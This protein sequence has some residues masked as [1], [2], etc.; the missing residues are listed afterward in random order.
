MMVEVVLDPPQGGEPVLVC[1]QVSEG[2]SVAAAVQASG[3]LEQYGGLS[4]ATASIG[5]HGKEVPLATAL[6]D[7]DRVEIYRDLLVDPK[8]ARRQRVKGGS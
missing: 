8:V 7:G 2:C 1:V 4:L 6:H 5:M 3:L